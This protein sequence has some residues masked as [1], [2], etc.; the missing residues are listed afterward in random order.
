MQPDQR[1]SDLR[2]IDDKDLRDFLRIGGADLIPWDSNVDF[3]A[4]VQDKRIGAELWLWVLG[5]VL[6]LAGLETFLAQKFSQ[7]K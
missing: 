4:A 5:I 6:L 1:E 3:Q 7:S 2:K